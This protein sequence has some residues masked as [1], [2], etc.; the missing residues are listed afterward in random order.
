MSAVVA[1][2]RATRRSPALGSGMLRHG[3]GAN[4]LGP[5]H[6]SSPETCVPY[7]PRPGID[8]GGMPS[9]AHAGIMCAYR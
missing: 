7:V 1:N 5:S 8:S 2:T 6:T 3:L 9:S 4:S